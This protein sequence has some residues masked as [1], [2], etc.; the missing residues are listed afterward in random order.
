[1]LIAVNLERN[2]IWVCYIGTYISHPISMQR[3][4][5]QHETLCRS[6]FSGTVSRDGRMSRQSGGFEEEKL[7]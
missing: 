3:D 7:G 1:M 6:F 2:A 4:Q 5:N